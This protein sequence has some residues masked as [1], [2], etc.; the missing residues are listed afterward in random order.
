MGNNHRSGSGIGRGV[1]MRLLPRLPAKPYN[2]YWMLCP[3]GHHHSQGGYKG[4]DKERIKERVM[5]WMGM[6]G[7]AAT[8]VTALGGFE[9]IKWVVA[10]KQGKRVEE[11]SADDSEFSV[12][13]KQIEFLQE[14]LLKKEERFA[15]Q[16]DALRDATRKE[17]ELT[18]EV[19]M[20][21][22]ERSLKLCERRM[23]ADRMP[24]S[25]Y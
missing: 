17:L 12:L 20:L 21:K 4:N 3:L 7:V 8:I 19:T 16:T 24:Q 10:R 5:D 14:Q 2:H 25:G 18:R 23:C 11:A 1:S 13:R 15:A 6:L 22:T 9:F